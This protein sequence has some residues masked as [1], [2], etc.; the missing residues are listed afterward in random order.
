MPLDAGGIARGAN[1]ELDGKGEG[2]PHADRDRL[3]MQQ[4][5]GIAGIGLE[6]VAE[7]MAEIEQSARAL[8]LFLVSLDDGSLGAGARLD[9]VAALWPGRG[10]D[11]GQ[12]A[13]SQAKNGA[14]PSS[15]Y[16]TTSA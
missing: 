1:P 14:S 2:E 4:T 8:L 7:G 10:E 3:A 11:L 16:F 9:R 13:S 5:V 15:P 12:F 6:R